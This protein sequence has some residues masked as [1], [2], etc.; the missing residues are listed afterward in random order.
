M[1]IPHV[2]WRCIDGKPLPC[3]IKIT[4]RCPVPWCVQLVEFTVRLSEL[5]PKPETV[6]CNV[7]RRELWLLSAAVV[8]GNGSNR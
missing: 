3:Q 2:I 7:C 6:R 4:G 1:P 8:Q 5:A